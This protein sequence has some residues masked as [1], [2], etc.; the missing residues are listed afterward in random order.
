MN[1]YH[2]TDLPRTFNV[3]VAHASNIRLRLSTELTDAVGLSAVARL[4]VVSIAVYIVVEGQ[5][6]A[7]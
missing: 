7:L 1:R 2:A 6:L 3:Q 5:F 4:G